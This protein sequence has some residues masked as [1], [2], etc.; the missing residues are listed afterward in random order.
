MSIHPSLQSINQSINHFVCRFVGCCM[1]GP[2][3]PLLR[4]V[5]TCAIAPPLTHHYYGVPISCINPTAMRHHYSSHCR[6]LTGPSGSL[7]HL[8]HHHGHHH[9]G[10]ILYWLV[11]VAQVP[12]IHHTITPTVSLQHLSMLRHVIS[13]NVMSPSKKIHHYH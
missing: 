2:I 11:A 13:W 3:V 6:H 10:D 9:H 12:P 4:Y 7:S 8:I 5:S 1:I